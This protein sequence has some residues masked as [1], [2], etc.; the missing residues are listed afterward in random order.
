MICRLAFPPGKHASTY[1][2]PYEEQSA[3]VRLFVLG[4]PSQPNTTIINQYGGLDFE[5]HRVVCKTM[6]Y[7]S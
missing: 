1:P 7:I 4:M 5:Y 6:D 2:S 3:K